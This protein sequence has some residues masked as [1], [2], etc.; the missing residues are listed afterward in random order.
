MDDGKLVVCEALYLH[1]NSTAQMYLNVDS[2]MGLF[3]SLP[4]VFYSAKY[5]VSSVRR[6]FS[7]YLF[8]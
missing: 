8:I 7:Y 3:F 1:N 4:F 2:I 6:G 5:F